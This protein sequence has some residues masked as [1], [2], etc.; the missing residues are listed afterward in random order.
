MIT[1]IRQLI[2]YH[3]SIFLIFI[4]FGLLKP[5]L[6]G[7]PTASTSTFKNKSELS[8]DVDEDLNKGSTE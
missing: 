3:L 5:N 8:L 2:A 6:S 4:S 1:K 7:E